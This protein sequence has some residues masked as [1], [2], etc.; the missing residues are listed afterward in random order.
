MYGNPELTGNPRST[1]EEECC[2]EVICE[3]PGFVCVVS[4]NPNSN[5]ELNTITL[6]TLSELLANPE[7][8]P[9]LKEFR[10]GV[11][12]MDD[13]ARVRLSE[14]LKTN[15]TLAHLELQEP[16]GDQYSHH[17]STS[18]PRENFEY[19]HGNR[20]QVLLKTVNSDTVG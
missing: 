2:L 17:G 1:L 15:S 18:I 19:A 5:N 7:M 14:A 11:D 9:G 6:A 3:R 12:S 8:L 10:L 20:G 4:L 16:E 13:A